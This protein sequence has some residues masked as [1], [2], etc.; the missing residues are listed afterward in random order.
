MNSFFLTHTSK[1]I[2]LLNTLYSMNSIHQM[3]FECYLIEWLFKLLL[4]KIKHIHLFQLL[5]LNIREYIL[6]CLNLQNRIKEMH[7]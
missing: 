5:L 2:H 7:L 3:I 4:D 6:E 1:K